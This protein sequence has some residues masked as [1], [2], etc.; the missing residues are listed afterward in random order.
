MSGGSHDYAYA[1][2]DEFDACSHNSTALRKAFNAHLK[3]VAVAMQQIEWVDSCDNSEPDAENA[4]KKALG[5]VT[6]TKRL[7]EVE[8]LK[9]EVARLQAQNVAPLVN[10]I[11][12][13]QRENMRL[14]QIIDGWAGL[15]AAHQPSPEGAQA[16]P[17]A[18]YTVGCPDC[19]RLREAL[20]QIAQAD[21]PTLE[22]VLRVAR[23]A[24]SG[25]DGK[26][27]RRSP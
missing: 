27:D 3:L 7:E 14:Q 21:C 17:V 11:D 26:T 6:V 24:L 20:S 16:Q 23:E 22:G 5:S 13:L 8:A 10:K 19:K 12:E 4:I 25:E 9:A 1:K 15:V 18:T 2:V